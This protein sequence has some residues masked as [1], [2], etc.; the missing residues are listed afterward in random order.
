MHISSFSFGAIEI[1]GQVHDHDVVL[2]RGRVRRRRKGPSKPYRDRFGHTPL[3]VHEDLPWSCRRLVIGTGAAGALPVM[4]EVTAEARRRHVELVAVPTEEA[5]AL[6]ARDPK[7]TNA[8][9][10]LTC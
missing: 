7:G 2:D 5:I 6:L 3:S 10:H 8:V 9:L 4:E 1:D